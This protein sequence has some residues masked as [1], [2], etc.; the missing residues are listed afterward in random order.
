MYRNTHRLSEG[1]HELSAE[2]HIFEHALQLVGELTATFGLQLSDHVLLGV[3]AGAASQ[4]QALRQVLFVKG[5][6]HVLS[7]R[8]QTGKWLVPDLRAIASTMS[9]RRLQNF[10]PK[11]LL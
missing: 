2:V 9:R 5:L 4:Q 11:P 7:L 3:S 8:D 10:A 6:K 1:H